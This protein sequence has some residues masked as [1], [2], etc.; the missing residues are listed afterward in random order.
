MTK[1]TRI[2]KE[3]FKIIID[4]C[5]KI[6][7]K[8]FE[9]ELFGEFKISDECAKKQRKNIDERHY[10]NNARATTLYI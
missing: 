1:N 8:D 5:N 2:T 4:E 10:T 3:Q 7:K 9:K 6:S